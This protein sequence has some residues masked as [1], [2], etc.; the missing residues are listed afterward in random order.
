MRKGKKEK[1]VIF[2]RRM[3]FRMIL[4]F[5]V[6]VAFILVLGASSYQKASAQIIESYEKSTLGTMEMMNSY[7][8]LSV[9]MVQST[10]KD[11]LTDET[12][13]KYYK[14]VLNMDSSYAYIPRQ[15]QDTLD[16]EVVANSL[17]TNIYFLSDE[18][19]SITTTQTKEP[20]LYSAYI[21]TSEGEQVAGD[22]YH[23]FLFG[24]RCDL[25]EKLKTDSS[26]YG[27]RL[28]KYFVNTRTVMLVDI[29]KEVVE[30]TL[31]SLEGGEGSIVGLVTGDGTEYLS[32]ASQKPEEGTVFVGKDYFENI[33][34]M[35][36]EEALKGA[37]YVEEDKYLFLYT[38]VE[39]RNAY[40]CAL[41]PKETIVGQTREIQK[42][43]VVLTVAACIVAVLMGLLLAGGYGRAIRDV[44]R[45]L[46]K[47]SG[48]DLTVEITTG[49]K[50]E[51]GLLAEGVSH[52]VGHMKKLVTGLKDVDGEIA[53]ASEKMISASGSFLETSR[54]I[55]GEIGEINQGV[56]RLDEEAALCQDQMDS[57][58]GR[59]SM[60][61]EN[62]TQISDLARE[63]EGGIETGRSSVNHLKESAGSTTRITEKIIGTIEKLSGQSKSIYKI[64]ETINEIAEQTNLLS[65]NASIEAARAGEAGKGFS[66]VAQEIRK[67]AD[68]SVHSA[69]EIAGIVSEIERSSQEA[70]EVARQ[71]ES[72]VEDQQKA[73]ELTTESF[74]RIGKQVE[75]LL[76]ALSVINE[77]VKS[78]E[79]GRNAT[80]ASISAIS[81]ISAQ[82]AAGSA[83]VAHSAE[84]QL[85]SVEQ[86]D[87]AVEALEEKANELNRILQEFVV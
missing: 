24:N 5:L 14:G 58:S 28:A 20:G 65:L 25:D 62:T 19:T 67:L 35:E 84:R 78:M 71:A 48:G 47:V 22:Q 53:G 46:K 12:L 61:G 85:A 66:V 44:L 41:I 60:V 64:I 31:S 16:H 3:S 70:A 4:A 13:V 9:D 54:G 38:A 30:S 86:L 36:G 33:R 69:E 15:F 11:Y 77:N 57:L 87:V 18:H 26:K 80:L 34:S 27:V 82:T 74:D 40:I 43:S 29:S 52:M 32:S 63:A 6:P 79:E 17:I 42:L 2:F 45:K 8:A 81:A 1:K 75:G 7:F 39:G 73:V 49:R 50:D 59:I 72:V 23:Y 55:Q 68:E 56:A 83:N 37:F 21:A 10:Y 76:G 51:F